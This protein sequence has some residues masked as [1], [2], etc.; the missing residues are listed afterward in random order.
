MEQMV[1]GFIHGE[2]IVVLLMIS[3]CCAKYLTK[4]D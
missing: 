2:L 4:K 3:A 1:T